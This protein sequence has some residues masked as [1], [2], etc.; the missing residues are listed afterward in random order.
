PSDVGEAVEFI[1]DVYR[2]WK[3]GNDVAVI[4]EKTETFRKKYNYE[5]LAGKVAEV[6]DEIVSVKTT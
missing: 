3:E 1:L 2:Q 6:F 4:S 5:S